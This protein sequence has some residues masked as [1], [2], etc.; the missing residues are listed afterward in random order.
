LLQTEYFIPG[1]NSSD[2][3]HVQKASIPME[4]GG[5]LIYGTAHMHTGAINAT[6]YGQVKFYVKFNTFFL[7]LFMFS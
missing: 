2:L 7:N 3:V 6:V 5:Y 4:K 1:N